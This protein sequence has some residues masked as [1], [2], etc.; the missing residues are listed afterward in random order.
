MQG[1]RDEMIRQRAYEIWE[2]EGH[3]EGRPEVHWT[4]ASQEI[5]R[6]ERGIESSNDSRAVSTDHPSAVDLQ[7]AS[8]ALK[9]TPP[10][11]GSASRD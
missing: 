11:F 1:S 10:G 6:E 9:G 2:R 5:E 3:P 8:E 7:N 4:Q